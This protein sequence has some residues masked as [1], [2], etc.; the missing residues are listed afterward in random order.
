MQLD[1]WVQVGILFTT[2]LV[3]IASIAI[4][5]CT[6]RQNSKMIEASTRPVVKIYLTRVYIQT[7]RHYLII[8]NFGASSARITDFKSEFDLN[9]L[10][11]L[12]LGQPFR[13]IVGTELAPGQKILTAFAPSEFKTFIK[14]W[15]ATHS[16]PLIFNINITYQSEAGIN[17]SNTAT[18]NLSC[19]SGIA[20][21]RPTI[22]SSE[23]ALKYS[24]H[25]LEQIA[26]NGI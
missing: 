11:C 21:A 1:Q 13:H 25:A 4:A 26:E 16:E 24:M 18:I 23:D 2:A 15:A 8:K 20:L 17:Y 6:L 7:V 22:N 3:G 19:V 9:N 10:T 14:K 12:E 5:I